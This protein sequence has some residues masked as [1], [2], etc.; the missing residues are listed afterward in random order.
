MFKYFAYCVLIT[1][2]RFIVSFND[3]KIVGSTGRP[4]WFELL[5]IEQNEHING[6]SK[7][8]KKKAKKVVFTDL[9][10]FSS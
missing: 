6:R 4:K 2:G 7:G 3:H 10:L 5:D 9:Q 1:Y 8:N